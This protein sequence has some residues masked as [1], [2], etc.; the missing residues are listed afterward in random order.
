MKI[1]KLLAATLLA[2]IAGACSSGGG[3]EDEPITPTPTPTTP[4]Q[5]T[6]KINIGTTVSAP[7]ETRATDNVFESGDKIGLFVVNRNA[8]GTAATLAATGNHVDNMRFAY[9]GTWTPDTPIYWKDNTTHADFYLYYPYVASVTS[10]TAMPFS[11]NA[12]Q[13]TEAAY[14]AC[15]MMVGSKSNVAPTEQAVTIDAKHVMS[16]MVIT[17]EAGNG[18]TA[19][20]LA[21]AD[22][23]VKVNGVKTAATVN[24]ATA[25]VT[26]SGD[27]AEVTPLSTTDGYKAFIV[28]QTVAEGNLITVTVDGRDFNL[29]KGFT[30]VSGKRHRFTVTL[31][32]T[33]NGV[34]VNI[35]KWDDDGTDNGG[36][37]E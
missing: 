9:S 8:D 37:A 18:F 16:Q 23:S 35:T 24:L 15:D 4:T 20:S 10:V 6:L 31:S 27:A 34:N 11:L 14:K 17:V 7:N 30:F 22:V 33:S 26:A 36:T 32:K 25:T 12:D 3:G 19:E 13:S 21:A 29:K 2:L 5:T 1:K 28:P